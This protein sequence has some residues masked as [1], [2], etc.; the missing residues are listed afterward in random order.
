MEHPEPSRRGPAG[1]ARHRNPAPEPDAD[2][3]KRAGPGK[4]RIQRVLARGG[5]ASRR[6]CEELIEA[7]RVTVNGRVV[8][9]LPA[10]VDPLRD[11]IE[12][13]GVP[14]ESERRHVYVMLNKPARVLS[15]A[16]T[17]PGDTRKTVVD[18]VDHP[19]A[20]RLFPVGRLDYETTGLLLLTNDGELTNRLTHPRYGVAKTYRAVVRGRLED[21]DAKRIEKGIYLAERREGQTVGARRT[22]RVRVEIVKR[23]RERTVLHLTLAEGRNRQV[24]RLLAA[25]DRPVKKLERIGMGPLRLKGLARG[26]WRELTRDEL[27]ELRK[28]AGR[29]KRAAGG[30]SGSKPSGGDRG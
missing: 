17:E 26:E 7:G 23:D 8:R 2:A 15:T 29:G 11:R 4:E 27:R 19:A 14:V 20:A 10:F 28:A 16:R 21:E 1:P 6:A 9:E 22:A 25:V 18:L 13:E 30:R 5:V 24:R 3:L 12:V